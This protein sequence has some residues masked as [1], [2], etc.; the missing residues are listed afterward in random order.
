MPDLT[1]NRNA[2]HWN[3]TTYQMHI[4]AARDLMA[5]GGHGWNAMTHAVIALVLIQKEGLEDARSR[6][7]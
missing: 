3:N 2:A 7:L 6:V 1:T 4:D 5:T